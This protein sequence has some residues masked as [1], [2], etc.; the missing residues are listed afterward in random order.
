MSIIARSG[1]FVQ[2]LIVELENMKSQMNEKSLLV[3]YASEKERK[4]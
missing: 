2:E 4:S 3:I 1:Y